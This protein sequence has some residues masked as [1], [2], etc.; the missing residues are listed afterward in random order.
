MAAATCCSRTPSCSAIRRLIGFIVPDEREGSAIACAA[1]LTC[2]ARTGQRPIARLALAGAPAVAFLPWL[3][4]FAAISVSEILRRHRQSRFCGGAREI[5][6]GV[7]RGKE[8]GLRVRAKTIV[9]IAG[10]REFESRLLRH[11]PIRYHS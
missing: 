4:R 5:R 7:S 3:R 6:I 1:L 9:P 10:D 2:S 11:I 8:S